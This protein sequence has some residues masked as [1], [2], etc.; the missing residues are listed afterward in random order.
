M[1]EIRSRKDLVKVLCEWQLE[2]KLIED[3]YEQYV[4]EMEEMGLQPMSFSEF[5]A[6]ERAGME[7]GGKVK[8]KKKVSQQTKL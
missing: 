8:K 6:R 7:D 5:L 1:T 4:F 2:L 3:M